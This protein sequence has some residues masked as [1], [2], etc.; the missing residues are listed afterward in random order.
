MAEELG[1]ELAQVAAP[2]PELPGQVEGAAVD[3]D[4]ARRGLEDLFNLF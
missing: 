3:V 4:A 2:A 1:I